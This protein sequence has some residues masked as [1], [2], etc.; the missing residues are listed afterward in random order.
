MNDL[1]SAASAIPRRGTLRGT[2]L[3]CLREAG[4]EGQGEVAGI[5]P[6]RGVL[7][8]D[9]SGLTKSTRKW[10]VLHSS[11]VI[12]RM[13]QLA[14]PVMK[15]Y[16][17]LADAYEGDNIFALFPGVVDAVKAACEVR[18]LWNGWNESCTGDREHYRIRLS[19]LAVAW[20]PAEESGGHVHG[21]GFTECYHLAED[22]AE[23]GVIILGPSA[24][25]PATAGLPG[26]RLEPLDD[27]AACGAKVL[28][29][30]PEL[31]RLCAEATPVPCEDDTHLHPNLVPL[32]RR[33]SP[34]VDMAANDKE[35]DQFLHKDCCAMM[36]R[37]AE[38]AKEKQVSAA[39]AEVRG[40]F[41]AH[42]VIFCEDIG[43]VP[44][45]DLFFFT[46]AT[47][48]L[49]ATLDAKSAVDGAVITGWGLHCGE[50]LLVPGTDVHWGDP[51]NTASKVGQ[52]LAENQEVLITEAV[53]NI[54]HEKMSHVKYEKKVLQR[55]GVDFIA[56]SVTT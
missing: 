7:V 20:G 50:V 48:A 2:A 51:V 32:A 16:G 37:I 23:G 29:L 14:L 46:A 31:E 56:Y 44:Q 40:H 9:L 15:K 38:H 42:G 5:L 39:L 18:A 3:G 34:G 4:K 54:V 30:S 6:K 27:P 41:S 36:F 28:Q 22:L 35:M 49:Q 55:S 8:N 33:C 45:R 43:V 21:A 47:G 12:V 25:E 13:R 1:L 52:D 19:G 11:A 26:I 24:L 53:Y 10:G 17:L